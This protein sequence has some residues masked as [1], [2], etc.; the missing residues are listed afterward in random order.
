[1]FVLVIVLAAISPVLSAILS[2][3]VGGTV[4][5]LM[6]LGLLRLIWRIS[7]DPIFNTL[8]LWGARDFF[9][10]APDVAIALIKGALRMPD[11]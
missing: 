7:A 4:L 1:M 5:A 10:H 2:P 9:P 8:I 6:L 11:R 3:I